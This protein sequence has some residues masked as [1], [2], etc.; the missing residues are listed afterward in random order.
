MPLDGIRFLPVV[1]PLGAD[2][3]K[4]SR[5]TKCPALFF[6]ITLES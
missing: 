5:T 4:Y 6:E 3:L 1:V 2:S